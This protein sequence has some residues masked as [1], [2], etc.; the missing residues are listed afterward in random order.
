MSASVKFSTLKLTA[1][2]DLEEIYEVIVKEVAFVGG[3]SN[4]DQNAIH[5]QYLGRNV[6]VDDGLSA[7]VYDFR[8]VD[9]QYMF[10]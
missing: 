5:R 9:K 10:R 4:P 6:L 2:S 1:N 7:E 3:L 8:S